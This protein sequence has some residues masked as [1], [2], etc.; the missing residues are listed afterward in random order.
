MLETA[1]GGEFALRNRAI[2]ALFLYS[3]IRVSELCSLTIGSVRKHGRGL[4][5]CRRKGGQW[6]DVEVADPF[7]RY[8]E[9]YLDTRT[10]R[11][12]MNA[13]LFKTNRGGFMERK[14]IYQTLAPVQRELGIAT[15]SHA[16]RHTYISEIDK[17]GGPTIARDLANHSSLKITNKYDHSTRDQRQAVLDRLNWAE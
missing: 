14:L 10:D 5:Y 15:G 6:K 7:Y 2:V 16:L 17:I 3:G 12:D 11:F 9:D 4:I 1:I 13:P 8:L